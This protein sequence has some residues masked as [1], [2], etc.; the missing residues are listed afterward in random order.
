MNHINNQSPYTSFIESEL[1]KKR[2]P[3]EYILKYKKDTE[4]RALKRKKM[5]ERK[6]RDEQRAFKIY[7]FKKAI[8]QNPTVL[9]I[10][11]WTIIKFKLKLLYNIVVNKFNKNYKTVK[12]NV[13]L[14]SE[15]KQLFDIAKPEE[16]SETLVKY[17]IKY[18]KQLS[19]FKN[20]YLRSNQDTWINE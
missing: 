10:K 2:V 6:Q 19:E 11:C 20:A 9:L 14:K 5:L 18:K 3:I 4:E 12:Y 17:C 13:T 15:E 16:I 1:N 7:K 8:N